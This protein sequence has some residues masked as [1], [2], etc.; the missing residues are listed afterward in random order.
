MTAFIE[1]I[2]QVIAEA[3]IAMLTVLPMIPETPVQQQQ[4]EPQ[5]VRF[6]DHK[7]NCV[8]IIGGADDGL[9]IVVTGGEHC[10]ERIMVDGRSIGRSI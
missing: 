1:A 6:T 8:Y 9:H 3:I 7:A 10:R 4:R 5:I 2:G